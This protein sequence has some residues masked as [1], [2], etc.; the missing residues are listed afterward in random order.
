MAKWID[1]LQQRWKLHSAWQVIIILIVFAFTGTTVLL[2]K[3]PLFAYWFP[4]GDKPLWASI[5]Y[6][7]LIF[8]VYNIFLLAYG[9]IFGQFKFFWEFEKRFFNRMFSKKSRIC[10]SRN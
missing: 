4:E 7:V 9:F 5:T 6:Y 10:M 1:G 2:I 8:P 3:R